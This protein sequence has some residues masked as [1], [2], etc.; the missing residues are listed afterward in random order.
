VSEP[1]DRRDEGDAEEPLA[2]VR[3][4]VRRT[5]GSRRDAA[6]PPDFLAGV[7]RRIRA[8]SRGRFFADGW[9]TGQT[10]ISYA[11]GG[12]ITIALAVVA[13]LALGPSGLR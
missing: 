3:L 12:L 11:L 7:Q 9:S 1:V 8:R 6:A 5:L 2:P 10:R 13:Y 4:L